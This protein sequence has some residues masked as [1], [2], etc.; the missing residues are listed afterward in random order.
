MLRFSIDTEF[1]RLVYPLTRQEYDLLEESIVSEGKSD[2]ILIWN[3]NVIDGF[4][5]LEICRQYEIKPRYEYTDHECREAAIVWVCEQQLQRKGIPEDFRKYVF[6]KLYHAEKI[7]NRIKSSR[8][9]RESLDFKEDK[10]GRLLTA[11]SIGARYG[12]CPSSVQK[13][14]VF[15]NAVDKIWKK[16]EDLAKKIIS[17]K[18]NFSHNTVMKLEALDAEQMRVISAS[19]EGS[20]R[21]R[22]VEVFQGGIKSM[23]A[24]DPDAGLTE[25][26]L[27]M[28]SWKSSI[29]RVKEK[30]DLS[31]ASPEAK[32]KLNLALMELGMCIMDFADALKEERK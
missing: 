13:Y 20:R 28:P 2:P 25:L 15:A 16:N 6:G 9:E 27:T 7:V 12:F 17:G 24:F 19:L 21:V 11:K 18:Y 1:K 10:A 3:G 22:P 31:I 30:S 5:R 4:E 26:I 14:G 8:G 29:L 32:R 23:P